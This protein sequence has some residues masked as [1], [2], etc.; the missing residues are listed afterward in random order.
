SD[1]GQVYGLDP[2]SGYERWAYASGG[3]VEAPLVYAEG[4]LWVASRGGIVAA[5]DPSRCDAQRCA[6][7]WSAN[8]SGPLRFAPA[9]GG[10]RV[11]AID[12]NGA[13]FV[14]DGESGQ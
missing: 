4:R 1:D 11:Y 12:E 9:V 10:G 2:D 5:V 3:A 8:T 13:L 7:L 14:F 6:A